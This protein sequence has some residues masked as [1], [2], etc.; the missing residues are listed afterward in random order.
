MNKADKNELL[1]VLNKDGS[2]TRRLEDR[3]VIHRHGLW[4]NEVACII[5]NSKKQILLQKRSKN[6]KSY[7]SSWGL[8]AGHIVGF[9]SV[10]DAIIKEMREELVSEIKPENIFLL[11]PKTKNER[12][13]NKCYATCFCAIIDK[14]A[15]D[16][17]FQ[18]EEIDELRWFDFEDFKKMVK[19]EKGTIFKNNKYY[20]SIISE[21]NKLFKSPNLYKKFNELVEKIEELDSQGEPTGRIVTR[22]FA[23]NYGIYHQIVSLFIYNNKNEVLLQKRSS[24]KISNS[25]LWDVSVSGHSR[26]GEDDVA[27]LIRKAKEET[28]YKINPKNMEF[29]VSYKEETE[30]NQKFLDKAFF[31]VYITKVS[32]PAQKVS[33]L[34]VEE[35]RF[36]TLAEIK[37]MMKS[38][39]E[40]VYKPEAFKALIKYFKK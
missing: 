20:K 40:L 18:K 13:D 34:D 5:I 15:K 22:E 30:F 10:A 25:S 19:N 8:C 39:K 32:A 16:F 12:P 33:N 37:D 9:D 21:L 11:V 28:K 31:N 17:L 24:R 23:H 1:Q 27:T 26:Y 14:P 4:H 3:A 38:N 29:L 7:P 35:T 2:P 6:K 36:F